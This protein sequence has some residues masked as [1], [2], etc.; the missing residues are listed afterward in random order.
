MALGDNTTS[1]VRAYG[2]AG[3]AGLPGQPFMIE[4]VLDFAQATTD[5]GT[6]LAANDVIPGLTIPANHLI[7][8][9]GLEVLTAHAG[10][11][12]NTDFDFG[13][14]GGDL[15]N[16]VD[17]FDFDGASVGDYAPTPAA[18][19][20][21]IIGGTSDTIDIEIQAMTGTTTGGKL[22][23]FAICMDIDDIGTMTADE[24]DR[25]TLA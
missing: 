8:H 12:S 13:I 1:T 16:F 3:K 18:Y 25:D 11:S 20:P 22:R 4:G 14:T 15:D 2:R 17:G 23:L 24:V 19:A 9:A 6:A 10:T 21:V 5:K 7:L